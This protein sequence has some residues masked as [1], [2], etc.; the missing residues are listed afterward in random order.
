MNRKFVSPGILVMLLVFGIVLAGCSNPTGSSSSD[1]WSPV[2]E[3][4]QLN[5]TWK[6][7]Y[8]QTMS[9]QQFIVNEEGEDAWTSDMQTVFGNMSVKYSAV[10][11]TTVNAS[12][13]TQSMNIAI[14]MTFIG[15]NISIVWPM[16]SAMFAGQDG[17]TVNDTTHSIVMTENQ[18]AQPM[19]DE[20]IA[21][22]LSSGLL[23][24]QTGNKI[25]IPA[26]T[27]G[28]G[29]PQIVMTKQ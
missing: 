14:T 18:A 7:A 20:D 8:S 11:S 28:E 17:V 13:M 2:T 10:I 24:N 12:A 25:K 21:E 29:S 5:G 23:I 27:M 1:I 16:I 19:T 9:I 6:G 22:M 4:N 26:D 15:G 3:L